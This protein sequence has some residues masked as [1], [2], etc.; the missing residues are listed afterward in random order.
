MCV[1]AK[2]ALAVALARAAADYLDWFKS[3]HGAFSVQITDC[4]GF[5]FGVPVRVWPEAAA[6]PAAEA[7]DGAGR[8]G[9][10]LSPQEEAIVAAL[11]RLS[12]YQS[13]EAIALALAR[14][15]D[16]RFK[17]V[18]TNLAD[19]EILESLSGSGYRIAPS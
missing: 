4:D 2:A 16:N 5:G 1:P 17:A 9:R 6:P 18:L 14:P 19:R 15:C 10:W 3:P 12:G 11:R 13:A 8:R 7:P